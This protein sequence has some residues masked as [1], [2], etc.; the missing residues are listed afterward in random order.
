MIYR[1]GHHKRTAKTSFSAS[2]KKVTKGAYFLC[3]NVLFQV[4]AEADM[5]PHQTQEGCLFSGGIFL[6]QC[7]PHFPFTPFDTRSAAKAQRKS[8]S[9][10]NIRNNEEH[11]LK[12]QSPYPALLGCA[13]PSGCC[14]CRW[15]SHSPWASL[16]WVPTCVPAPYRHFLAVLASELCPGLGWAGASWP[17]LIPCW[18]HHEKCEQ[19]HTGV[20]AL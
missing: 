8:R 15:P 1:L 5:A 4:A 11:T 13:Q 3:D 16:R 6:C 10:E 19:P 18:E 7:L 9:N 12:S 20:Q 17:W 2:S 14:D